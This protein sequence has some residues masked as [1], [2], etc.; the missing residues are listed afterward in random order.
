MDVC[1]LL[2]SGSGLC[3]GLILRPEES[4]RLWCVIVSDLETSRMKR[5]W[6]A[7]GCYV[8]VVVVVVVVVRTAFRPTHPPVL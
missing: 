5:L 2:L 7:L 6:A 4:Y 3:D 8:I 1:V